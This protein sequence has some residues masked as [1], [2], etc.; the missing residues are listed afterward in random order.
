MTRVR[1]LRDNI[2]K[3]DPAPIL[4]EDVRA[5]G[6]VAKS[7][8]CAEAWMHGNVRITYEPDHGLADGTRVWIECDGAQAIR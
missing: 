8:Q 2:D 7:A 3:G 6:T 5:D 4:I 1:V